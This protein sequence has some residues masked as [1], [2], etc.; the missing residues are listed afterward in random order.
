M[1]RLRKILAAL[2]I[3]LV[4]YTVIGFFAAP[5]LIKSV[6]TSRLSESLHRPV[7]IEE[8]KLNPFALSM[9]A[10][11]FLVRERDSDA[12]FFSFKEL[13]V[14]LE[15]LSLYRLGPVLREIRLEEPF[16]HIQRNAD[17][18]YN[19]SDLA[20]STEP[21]EETS[22]EP[23]RFSLNNIQVLNGSI[24]FTDSPKKTKHRVRNIVV[25]IPFISNLPHAVETFVVPGLQATINGTPFS[26]M[27][28]T[29]P[30]ADSRE[31]VF[32]LNI[33]DFDIP[34]Y[35]SY[36]PYRRNFKIVSAL[37]HGLGSL[38]FAQHEKKP[39]SLILQGA[40][41]LT[42]VNIVNLEDK[43]LGSVPSLTV[44]VLPSE[45]IEPDIHFGKVLLQSPEV[46][47][48]RDTSGKVELPVLTAIKRGVEKEQEKGK[49]LVL[50]ADEIQIS[51]GTLSFTD[52]SLPADFAT[53]LSPVDLI[54]SGFSTEPDR[55]SAFD[56]S[57]QSES[58]ET[59][60][61]AGNFS[62]SPLAVDGSLELAHLL[63]GKYSPYYV[64]YL[65]F[66]VR[67][68]SINVSASYTYA[69][70]DQQAMKIS[71][72][73]VTLQSIKLRRNDEKEDF[74]NVPV[75]E[76]R[77]TTIDFNAQEVTISE[78]S[79]T[80]GAIDVRRSEDGQV[81]VQLLTPRLA[82]RAEEAAR[83]EKGKPWVVNIR[84]LAYDNFTIAAEDRVPADPVKVLASQIK[85]RVENLS[86]LK[87]SRGS[88]SCSL[89]LNKTGTVSV[90]S[91]FGINPVAADMTLSLKDMD[92]I[93]FQPYITEQMN[94]LITDGA[95]SADGALKVAPSAEDGR[96]LSYKG[97]VSLNRFASL[98][99]AN[100]NDFLTWNSF[101]LSGMD[102]GQNPFHLHIKEVALT[103]FYS[104]LIINLDGSLN[105][106]D[107]LKKDENETEQHSTKAQEAL[108]EEQDEVQPRD[109]R[110]DTVT[111]QGGTIN[112]TDNHIQPNYY[113]SFLE[114][115]GRVSGLSSEKDITA[116]VDLKGKL[117]NYAPLDITGTIDPLRENLYVNLKI[118]FRDMDLS[119]VSPYSGK[120]VGYTIQKGKLGL[121]LQYL[122]EERKLQSTNRIFL[123]Q[124]TFGDRV[125]SPEALKVPVRL[126]VSLLKNRKGEIN[127][128]VPVSGNLDN[129]EFNYG[130]I[131][132][133]V[134]FNLLVK[135]ATSP[136]AV[137][138]A[139]FGGGEELSYVEFYYGSDHI[140]ESAAAK[141]EN[142]VTALADRPALK[143]EI[144]GYVDVEQD[145]QGL[146]QAFFDRK[147]K[148]QKL[149]DLVRKGGT[150]PSVDAVTVLAEEYEG[151]LTKAYKAED[152]PKPRNVLGFAKKLPAPEMEK[153]MFTHII[154]SDDDLGQLA[155][156][157]ALAVRDFILS[158]GKIEP[159]R[160]FIVKAASLQ[161][162][163]K[164][165]LKNSRVDFTLK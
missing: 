54:I 74:L 142:L 111:L 125:E 126:A 52:F 81:N 55:Q 130:K 53:K 48:R 33:K 27:G 116:D 36:V 112:F 14:N 12:A 110:I 139:I 78:I 57:L 101:Y 26:I 72:M 129:P 21:G 37:A 95:V 39:P 18:S 61:L 88:L 47:I 105:V 121:D 143:L 22:R 113:A 8:I 43:L 20:G 71:S 73:D 83:E 86:T 109:I 106:Q 162:D 29:K 15:A 70:D 120:Y 25:A 107:V 108:Q 136:F 165:P 132:F 17:E 114:L 103:D 160:V 63:P 161:P 62:L 157:R 92:I 117:E 50:N 76:L 164:E 140:V 159:Q 84:K 44:S 158:S 32:E 31:T 7:T 124:L 98:D 153:L 150:V 79:S 69:A 1:T 13:Y 85:L 46:A 135:A 28:K 141:L 90:K 68:G 93:P 35:L 77:D 16:V 38:S 134:I 156:R 58:E 9:S 5:P 122:I 144:A 75:Y 100:S 119:P 87:N 149:K 19:F 127:L 56:L 34:Y 49:T 24:D 146:Q 138:G 59:L 104:R 82:A 65:S 151:Y 97:D 147:I 102:L 30:F 118:N 10:M 23:L 45:L 89:K 4:L 155:S 154:I 64:N 3:I 128:D 2:A 152:F 115:G 60:R 51:G 123:D 99:K 145:H 6:L 96:A 94:I 131:V 91:S 133:K 41:S 66:N 42:N 80:N 148:A 11:G 137:L 40:F 67:E 163:E